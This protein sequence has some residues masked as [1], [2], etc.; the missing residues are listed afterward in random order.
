MHIIGLRYL[1]S[2]EILEILEFQFSSKSVFLLILN[3]REESSSESPRRRP[4]RADTPARDIPTAPRQ[5]S[6]LESACV[7]WFYG[8]RADLWQASLVP[9]LPDSSNSVT[10]LLIPF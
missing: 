1:T 9:Y 10:L 5:F 6:Y 2:I 8:D 7:S 3:Y 4:Q